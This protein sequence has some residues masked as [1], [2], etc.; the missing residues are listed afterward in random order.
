MIK[1]EKPISKDLFDVLA[2][3]LCRAGLEYAK[4]KKGL[5]CPD[6]GASY[7]IQ[8]GVPILLTPEG[9]KRLEQQ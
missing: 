3:P 9:K 6:C 8:G 4:G 1:K 5:V 7:P 2:C